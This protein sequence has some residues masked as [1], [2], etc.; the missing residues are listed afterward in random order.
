MNASTSSE[1]RMKS[2]PSSK[3]LT[4]SSGLPAQAIGLT[5]SFSGYSSGSVAFVPP[6]QD[7]VDSV[8]DSSSNPD[9]SE[10]ISDGTMG[11]EAFDSIETEPSAI[12]VES[13]PAEPFADD[14][15]DGFEPES[16]Q[17]PEGFEIIA[18]S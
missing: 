18:S 8:S 1:F 11:N 2:L 16:P 4:Q 15:K 6:P 5:T 12:R 9:V 3:L 7:P 10:K 13:G 17:V 14:A